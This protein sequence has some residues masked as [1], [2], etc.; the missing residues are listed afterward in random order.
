MLEL[1]QEARTS[2]IVVTHDMDIAHRMDR[3]WRL[4]DGVLQAD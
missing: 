4:D 3:I 1:N 2:L